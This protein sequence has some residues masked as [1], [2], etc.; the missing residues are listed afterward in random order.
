MLI[1]ELA[2]FYGWTID[3]I[4]SLTMYELDRARDFM[5]RTQ[6]SEGDG[7]NGKRHPPTQGRS[8]R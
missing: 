7:V 8:N 5:K 3:Y 1:M 4:R 6:Q 2:Y